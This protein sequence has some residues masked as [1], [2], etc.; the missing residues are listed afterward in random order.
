[1]SYN[2][3]IQIKVYLLIWYSLLWTGLTFPLDNCLG[4]PEQYFI[5]EFI[6]VTCKIN[7][8]P[9]LCLNWF[10]LWDIIVV[11]SLAFMSVKKL[12]DLHSTY[13]MNELTHP[14]CLQ[15]QCTVPIMFKLNQ[16]FRCYCDKMCIMYR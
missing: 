8:V 13:L 4:V 1:M 11:I 7:T 12:W 9:Q 6:Q 16:Y 10:N 5:N 2:Q 14:R 3:T 15:D